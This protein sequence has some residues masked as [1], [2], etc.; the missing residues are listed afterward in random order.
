MLALAVLLN[1]AGRVHDWLVIACRIRPS[2]QTPGCRWADVARHLAPA[3]RA[4]ATS[5]CSA[6]SSDF[7]FSLQ[8]AGRS[9][10]VR[11]AMAIPF[12]PS[13]LLCVGRW[14]CS[15]SAVASGP[16]CRS[17]RAPLCGA[18]ER[19]HPAGATASD[20]TQRGGRGAGHA[21]GSLPAWAQPAA[22]VVGPRRTPG[23]AAIAARLRPAE[24][25]S[26]KVSELMAAVRLPCPPSA[27]SCCRQ[28]ARR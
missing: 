22:A 16:V 27:S 28:T 3:R 14:P 12:W 26:A 6:C 11:A 25:Q 15:P 9:A 24:P 8:A 1:A 4:P 20:G 10:S 2:S 23:S 19:Y 13:A 18:A 7:Y 5:P 21:A 17:R